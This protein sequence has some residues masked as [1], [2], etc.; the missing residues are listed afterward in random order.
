L[1]GLRF[2]GTRYDCG[3]K[4]GYMQANLVF[5]LEHPDTGAGLRDFSKTLDL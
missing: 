2:Q 3:S 1:R 4:L 5:G